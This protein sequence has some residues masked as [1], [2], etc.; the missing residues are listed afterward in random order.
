M[1]VTKTRAIEICRYEDACD[2]KFGLS[3]SLV[4]SPRSAP[5]TASCFPWHALPRRHAVLHHS[6]SAGHHPR[7]GRTILC[8]HDGGTL[9]IIL[10][11]GLAAGSNPACA[12]APRGLLHVL[13]PYNHPQVRTSPAI[14]I[15]IASCT[16]DSGLA[17]LTSPLTYDSD[18]V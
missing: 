2:R 4:L 1:A 14:S 8:H 3:M 5:A 18:C 17:L 11:S 9:W 15:A 6:A 7:L 13:H 16:H 12:H 10:N